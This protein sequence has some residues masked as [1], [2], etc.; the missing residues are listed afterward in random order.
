MK[1]NFIKRGSAFLVSTVLLFGLSLPVHAMPS[2]EYELDYTIEDYYRYESVVSD[3]GYLKALVDLEGN[4]LVDFEYD[5]LMF[6]RYGDDIR[7]H[8]T[9]MEDEG[10]IDDSGN[11]I[12]PL[13]YYGIDA[14]DGNRIFA[15]NQDEEKLDIYD[16]NGE[17]IKSLADFTPMNTGH[18]VFP[19][20]DGLYG[21]ACWNID[22]NNI[23]SSY[24]FYIID[25]DGNVR[26]SSESIGA[27]WITGITESDETRFL[28]WNPVNGARYVLAYIGDQINLL[29]LN[30]DGSFSDE[31]YDITDLLPDQSV[32]AFA[33]FDENGNVISGKS[34]G[35]G[36]GYVVIDP[37]NHAVV[38]ELLT[39]EQTESFLR[40]SRREGE[41]G[42]VMDY[43]YDTSGNCICA[44]EDSVY[45]VDGAYATLDSSANAS[46]YT[47]DGEQINKERLFNM[48]TSFGLFITDDSSGNCVVI[49]RY[50]NYV[51]DYDMFSFDYSLYAYGSPVKDFCE[52][53]DT[54]SFA[55]E[56]SVYVMGKAMQP[57]E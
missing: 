6:L 4:M 32:D 27:R 26:A 51:G 12:I 17:L 41:N 42:P 16:Y 14:W 5:N 28:P 34:A 30:D 8:A 18:Y 54:Y 22:E 37:V 50:G 44:T 29:R 43:L 53:E 7:L 36:D 31:M 25:A 33:G 15:T 52:Y 49:D 24:D 21:L 56:Y 11:V 46:I 3:E 1:K 57:D 55:T 13:E 9:Y 39:Y 38:G 23:P 45:P 47:F 40:Y 10:V 2:T 20:D 19:L 35:Y 48:D